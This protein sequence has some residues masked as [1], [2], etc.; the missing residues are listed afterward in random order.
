MNFT[1]T[2][3]FTL[4]ALS[5]LLFYLRCDRQPG[6][7]ERK[8]HVFR[9]A[10]AHACPPL[11][12]GRSFSCCRHI[13]TSIEIKEDN[14]PRRHDTPLHTCLTTLRGFFFFLQQVKQHESHTLRSV[15]GTGEHKKLH[16]PSNS[17]VGGA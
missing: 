6:E 8:V 1:A 12:S 13:T 3:A 11:I 5:G 7:R 16:S 14:D 2:G 17:G 4:K 9:R 15:S 10:R